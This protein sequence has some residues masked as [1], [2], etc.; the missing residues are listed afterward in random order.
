LKSLFQ[1]IDSDNSGRIEYGEFCALLGPKMATRKTLKAVKPTPDLERS[2]SVKDR[3]QSL[4][5]RKKSMK[6]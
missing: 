3:K 4:K 6:K 1:Y 5:K 2:T